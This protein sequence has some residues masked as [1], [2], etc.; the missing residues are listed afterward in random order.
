MSAAKLARPILL[1][2]VLAAACSAQ[3][4]WQP[5]IV[6]LTASDGTILKASY[7]AAARP[8]PGVL[9]LH[10]CN[11]QR[12]SWDVLA[13]AMNSVGIN[14]LTVDYRG[15][16]ESGGPRF[17][18]LPPDDEQRVVTETWPG[19]I[20]IAFRYLLS[21]PGVQHD[22][23]G[24]GGASCGVNHS[25]QLARR[26]AE[27]K[28]LML[29]SGATNRDGRLFLQATNRLPVFTAGADDDEFGDLTEVMQWL[30]SISPNPASRFE[31]YSTGGHGA[32][33]FTPHAELPNLIARWF[34]AAL[35]GKPDAV[36]STNGSR[37][38]PAQVRALEQIDQ[39]GGASKAG[40]MLADAREQDP[41]ANIFPE[42]LVNLLGYEHLRLGD[43]KAAIEIMQLNVTAYPDSPNAYDSLSDAYLADGQ[44]ELAR[45][46]AKTALELL[47]KD[48]HDTEQRRKAIQE[49]AEGKLKQ[50]ADQTT[51][52][53]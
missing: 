14:V 8:G 3:S 49:S 22:M 35:G 43:S 46:Q 18:K 21:Q 37:L 42:F 47:A 41:G 20:D 34:Q 23:I 31:R 48:N 40:K 6:N 11:Q 10:Q 51:H 52:R 19:D 2:I 44:K 30:F 45:T 13:Q 32:A 9:L 16:G 12:K 25:V 7:F 53:P 29:L 15:F 4:T 33:M 28:A 17:E 27:V 26:H 24:A 50:L 1:S 36:P 38:P 5:R 39:P